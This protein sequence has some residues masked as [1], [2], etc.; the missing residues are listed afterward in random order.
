MS[1]DLGECSHPGCGWKGQA[2]SFKRH[3]QGS[4]KEDHRRKGEHEG[5][6]CCRFVPLKGTCPDLTILQ[7]VMSVGPQEVS[8]LHLHMQGEFN[9]SILLQCMHCSFTTNAILSRR[10]G[11]ASRLGRIEAASFSTSHKQFLGNPAP[12][13]EFHKIRVN[14]FFEVGA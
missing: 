8:S 11:A 10:A 9:R 6:E 14:T 2:C 7:Q 13:D 3:K 4:G 12:M 1:K 5:C